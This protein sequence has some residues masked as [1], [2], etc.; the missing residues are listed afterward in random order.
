MKMMRKVIAVVIGF[1]LLASAGFAA[2]PKYSGFLGDLYKNLQPG[3][4]GAAK[5]RW[6]KPGVMFGKY[7]KFMV[8]S[9]I[10]FLAD[11]SAYKGIDPN[12]M[13]ELA[14]SFNEAMVA[15]FKDKYPI[16][17]EPGPDVARIRV[18]ITGVKAS[19]PVVSG[20][21]SIM[22]IGLA[23]SLVKKGATGSWSGSGATSAELEILDTTTNEPIAA[24][25]DDQSAAFGDRFSKWGSAK[26]A[27]KYWAEHIVAFIDNTRA[28]KW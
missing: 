20:V 7:D 2:E 16:V 15:A 17:V 11:D 10:F 22:P 5:M 28:M 13:K 6:M 19:K 14:D 12:E 24:A 9:V 23:F 4:E 18:A 8:D 26:E 21:S 3:P 1:A 25:V 27:F